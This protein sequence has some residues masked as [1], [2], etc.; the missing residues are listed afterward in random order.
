MAATVNMLAPTIGGTYSVRSGAVYTPSSIGIIS[1]VPS[2]GTDIL[3]L[4]ADGCI[5]VSTSA[6]VG[7]PATGVTAQEFG[8]AYSHTTI[9]TL[10]AACVLPAIAGGASLGVG[11][12]LYTLPAGAQIITSARMAVGITQTQAH[13]NTDTPTVGLGHVVASG[14]IAVLSGTAS[15]QSIAVGKAAANCTGTAT[16]QTAPASVT[17]FALVSESGG[18]KAVYFN[19]A[20]AWAAS[21]DAGA[22]L[23]GTVALR[24]QTLA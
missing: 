1:N 7:T 2:T 10:G 18:V 17:P 6:N 11:T 16:V 20:F 4:M 21:G 22:L 8:D 24:W 15:F 14:V 13:I 9:L 23:S 3:D 19:A 12:L 5:V